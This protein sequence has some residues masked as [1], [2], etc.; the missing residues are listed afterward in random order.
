MVGEKLGR[1]R[2]C[3][4]VSRWKRRPRRVR[5]LRSLFPNWEKSF[6]V[7]RM[8]CFGAAGATRGRQL[9][10]FASALGG[11][12]EASAG[13]H[14]LPA[15]AASKANIKLQGQPQLAEEPGLLKVGQVPLVFPLPSPPRENLNDLLNPAGLPVPLKPNTFLLLHLRTLLPPIFQVPIETLSSDLS[16]WA[17]PTS[18]P[19]LVSPVRQDSRPRPNSRHASLSNSPQC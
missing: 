3:A 7:S 15:R 14:I 10:G 5:L 17:S 16:K 18:F 4:E 1:F 12:Q 13:R 19:M 11:C 2:G 8:R 9:V 6:G